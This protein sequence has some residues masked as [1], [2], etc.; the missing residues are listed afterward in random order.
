MMIEVSPQ[1]G[2]ARRSAELRHEP[3]WLVA[4]GVGL[5]AAQAGLIWL[6]SDLTHATATTVPAV[7]PLI[8]GLVIPTA[9]LLVLT[10]RLARLPP[11][12]C[13]ILIIFISGLFMRSLWLGVPAPL[14]DD[15]QRYL[16]DGAVTTSGMDPYRHPPERFLAPK[17]VP[18]GFEVI[19][20][21]GQATL[22]RINFP[23]LRTIYPSTAQMAFAMAHLIAPFDVDGLRIVF[24]AFECLTFLLL[25]TLLCAVK[26]STIWSV[27]YWW[28]PLV[29]F[30][31]IG[32]AHAD[33]LVPTFVLAALLMMIRHRTYCAVALLGVGAG[34]KIWPLLLLPLVL[35]RARRDPLKLVMACILFAAVLAVAIGPVALSALRPG[36][37]LTAYASSWGSNNAF[38]AW[39]VYLLGSL[40]GPSNAER[41]LRVGVALAALA[42]S[43]VAARWAND[44]SRTLTRACLMVAASVFYLSPAQ[45]PWYAVWFLPLSSILRSWPL[46]FASA[47]LPFYY[48]F[49]P[50]WAEG[51]GDAFFFGAAYLHSVPVLIWLAIE[52]RMRRTTGCVTS[53]ENRRA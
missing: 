9:L 38:F 28:N 35:A 13:A 15:F 2:E 18:D 4:C 22:A 39:S 50:L 47:T 12:R 26:V 46:L 5:A 16:W 33:A 7:L 52:N 51:R 53:G 20:A 31:L 45:F 40:T 23:D 24:L 10:P 1:A 6:T 42:T 25:L 30:S 48:L 21:A 49:Y 19:A 34:V 3:A 11:T 29:A 8:L 37:G 17:L 43:F 41:A 14:E 32:L 36:S 44:S 27:L